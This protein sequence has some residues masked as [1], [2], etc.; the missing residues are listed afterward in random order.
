MMVNRTCV[1]LIGFMGSGKSA[2]GELAARE[3]GWGFVDTDALIE[4][5]EGL[6]IPDLFRDRG[7]GCFR[8]LESAVLRELAAR[9][10]EER[11]V[12]ATGGGMPCFGDNLSVMKRAGLVVYLRAPVRE[13]AAR[14]AG[15][16]GRP[17][18][19]GRS[20]RELVR[21][22]QGRRRYYRQAHV[23]VDNRARRSPAEAARRIAELVRRGR[24]R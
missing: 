14:A 10:G 8:D 13:L 20:R 22:F 23:T 21:L 15:D 3:L 17:L 16:A 2:V 6:R 18:A 5:R 4:R 7:E 19:H 11:L 12:V 24:V 1:F 9:C